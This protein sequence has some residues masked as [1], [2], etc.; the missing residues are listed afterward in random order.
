V[1]DRLCQ[2]IRQH[3]LDP[4]QVKAYAVD[5]CGCE[6]LKDAPR[7]QIETFVR[8]LLRSGNRMK[9]W[10]PELSETARDLDPAT[11]DGIFLVRIDRARYCW[12]AR[13]SAYELRLSILEPARFAG[14]SLVSHLDCT[15]KA[16]WKLGWFPRLRLQSRAPVPE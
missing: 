11:S 6:S 1:R 10:L 14:R 2:I 12:H 4:A 7:E 15:P 5:F 9:R 13:K 16:M 3:Q 8:P